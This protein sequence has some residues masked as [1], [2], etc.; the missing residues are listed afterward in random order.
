MTDEHMPPEVARI[1]VFVALYRREHGHGPLWRE[2]AKFAGWPVAGRWAPLQAKRAY[3]RRFHALVPYGFRYDPGV[4]YSANV[5]ED[6]LA[7]AIACARLQ[8]AA[9]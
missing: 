6:G 1:L 2:I 8:G 5:T 9:A 4:T 7:A 3:E